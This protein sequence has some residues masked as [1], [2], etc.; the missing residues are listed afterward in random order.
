MPD[1]IPT[2]GML[3]FSAAQRVA[4][5][6]ALP[7]ALPAAPGYSSLRRQALRAIQDLPSSISSF[8]G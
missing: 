6:S 1:D 5:L 7:R 4:S 3:D 2:S 8:V